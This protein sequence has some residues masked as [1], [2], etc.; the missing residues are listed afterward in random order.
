MYPPIHPRN[1]SSGVH[2]QIIYDINWRYLQDLQT[3]YGVSGDKLGQ[4]SI[5]EENEYG[6]TVR[7]AYLALVA[8]HTVNGVAAIHSELIKETIFKD[9]FNVW[10]EKFQNKT[11][12]VTQRRWLAFC[13]PPLRD[14]IT[15]TLGTESWIT[16]L[17]AIRSLGE[18]ADDPA[19]QAKWVDVKKK[20]KGKLATL[21]KEQTGDDVNMDA[22]FD[23]HVKR[24]HEYK[25]QL[26]N[27]LSVILRYD[28]IKSMS[29]DDKQSI[30]P[31][32][33]IIGGKAA[34][35]YDIAKRIIKLISAVSEKVNNDPDVGDLLKVYFI[36]NY[37]VSL[38]E[39]IIPGSDI[40]QQ[41]STAGTEA[42]GTSNM[43]FAMNGSLIIGTMDGANVELAEE[44]G[45]ENLFIFGVRADEVP[46]LRLEREGYQPD[47]QFQ[48]AIN[49]VQ[50]GHFG[51][52]DYF[53]PLVD[54]V[55]GSRDYYLLANDFASYL[56]AQERVDREWKDQKAWV[57]RSILSTAGTGKFSSDRT[58]AEY[59]NEIWN[60]KPC[61]R[62]L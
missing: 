23:V 51:W 28:R 33:V 57:R 7:M 36:P 50:N 42:S 60:V 45:E 19:F 10:P 46:R 16:H 3:N 56:D 29:E 32:V 40:N 38:A 25:R 22:L 6:K 52:A 35:G 18:H 53:Q 59:A 44:I 8:S 12:G 5:I 1:A 47:P 48:H 15:E 39:T 24:I 17:D 34:P 43:K 20:A 37:N 26:L 21:L 62:E 49:L 31:R 2:Q 54:S 11:N 30:V 58:I 27:I 13:N 4:M 14:L 55:T 61:P 41:I 9:F